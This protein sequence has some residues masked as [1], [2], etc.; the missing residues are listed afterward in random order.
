MPDP[1]LRDWIASF[2]C[3]TLREHA[4]ADGIALA[5][6]TPVDAIYLDSIEIGRVAAELEA[7]LGTELPVRLFLGD[8]GTT[9]GDLAAGL[10]A[11]AASCAAPPDPR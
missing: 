5:E 1:E 6:S 11:H 8:P 10:A 7:A 2:L 3:E 9:F 4:A